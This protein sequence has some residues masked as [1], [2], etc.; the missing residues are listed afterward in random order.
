[1]IIE[2]LLELF[3]AFFS[4]LSVGVSVTLAAFLGETIAKYWAR[5][6]YRK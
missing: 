2:K 5:K 4:G 6:E 1:M 3:Q